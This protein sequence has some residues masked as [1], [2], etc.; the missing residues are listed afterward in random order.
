[1]HPLTRILGS[2]GAALALIAV[3]AS[4]DAATA[5]QKCQATIIKQSARFVKVKA[6]ALQQCE[7]TIIKEGPG[8]GF[9]SPLG[10]RCDDPLGKTSATIAKAEQR[11]KTRVE[12]ACGGPDKVCGGGAD[13]VPLG[14]IGWSIGTCR[15]FEL[16]DCD[17]PISHCGGVNSDGN[18]ITDCLLCMN[19]VA[20]DQAMDLY[21]NDLAAGEFATGS[22]AN[23]CQ[24]AI[25][26]EA[27]RFLLKKSKAIAKCWDRVNAGVYTG[28]CPHGDPTGRTQT[29][30][31]KAEARKIGRLCRACGGADRGCDVT[32]GTVAG[33]GGSDD[34]LP[35]D[36]RMSPMACPNAMVPFPPSTDCGA[37]DDMDGTPNV[38]DSLRELILCV[39]CV[40]E[41]KVDCISVAAVPGHAAYPTQCNT[42][43]DPPPTGACP[44][45]IEVTANGS[46]ADL[47]TG[48]T[49]IGHD[50]NIPSMGRLTLNVSGCDN[51]THPCGECSVSGPIL[52]GG[53]PGFHNRRCSD[54]TWIQCTTNADCTTAGAAGPCAFFFGAPLPLS[55]GGIPTCV[56]NEIS[57]S[58][59]GT[60]NVEDGSGVTVI[61][62]IA[63]PF[64]GGYGA[65]SISQPC[66]RCLPGACAGGRCCDDGERVGQPCTVNGEHPVFGEVSLDCPPLPG[67]QAGTL[68]I[69]LPISSGVQTANLTAAS[70]SCRANGWQTK[71]CFCDTCNAPTGD[72]C[73]SDADCPESP[74]GTPGICGGL[75][76]LGG[77]D[78]GVPCSVGGDCDSGTCGFAGEDSAANTCLN[79]VCRLN[80]ADTDSSGEAQCTTGPTDNLCSIEQFRT[81]SINA[82]C[83]PPPAG[84]CIL[85]AP[86]QTCTTKRRQCF[87]DNGVIGKHC[88]RGTNNEE[89]C[90]T[91]A[92]CPDQVTAGV[93]CGGGSASVGGASDPP[94][95][96]RS[97]PKFG[98][99]FCVPHT[100]SSAVNTTA[101]LPGLGRLTLS[102]KTI[103]NP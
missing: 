15:D 61:S 43:V 29:I 21:A 82:D 73:M 13:D 68:P 5:A 66:P 40:T 69:T 1:M 11:F 65:E 47:D 93:F 55:A 83:E 101:G 95:G 42:C 88:F 79:G 44:T 59:S 7:D 89:P 23:K 52:N 51:A 76:C 53:G 86:G 10:G 62:L 103:L 100:A 91:L 57:G 12:N 17:K 2:V 50:F 54:K 8:S 41:F 32:V 18:G 67:A 102:A 24:A 74:V 60:L 39:D 49:G 56:T 6:R 38:V 87:P 78:S 20:I 70:P 94:C 64:V 85:C 37:L 26:K 14:A 84:T 75:R 36:I 90:N 48:W 4:A 72:P 58:L 3:A 46:D 33:S 31:A 30:I 97:R 81:C 92:D 45:S 77:M 16:K 27:T 25:G 63:R 71:K 9:T 19:E 34:L 96:N 99:L 80:P 28:P 35:S 22:D 98:A